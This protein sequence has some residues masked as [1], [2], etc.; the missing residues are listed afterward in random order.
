M[1]LLPPTNPSSLLMVVNLDMAVSGILIWVPELL[2]L[3]LMAKYLLISENMMETSLINKLCKIQ[4][5]IL[6]QPKLSAVL[7]MMFKILAQTQVPLPTMISSGQRWEETS[8][9]EG[10]YN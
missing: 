6:Q 3:L 10:G 5:I 1:T 8:S 2:I 7:N 4:L 9:S